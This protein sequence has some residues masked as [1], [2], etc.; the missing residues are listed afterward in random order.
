MISNPS[1]VAVATPVCVT[2]QRAFV[3][4][5]VMKSTI[6]WPRATWILF[7]L[8]SVAVMVAAVMVRVSFVLIN[9]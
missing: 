1:T 3:L 5:F 8:V 9:R 6:F 7:P 2:V 4:F